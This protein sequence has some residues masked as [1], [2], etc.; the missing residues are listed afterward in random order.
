MASS[1]SAS[2]P[3][4]WQAALD[5][6]LTRRLM[7][8]LQRPGVIGTRLAR[9]VVSRF[10][11]MAGGFPLLPR[12]SQ[13]WSSPEASA[14][15]QVPIV[16]AQ[17]AQPPVEANAASPTASSTSSTSSSA[18]SAKPSQRPIVQ[19]KAVSAS[20][21]SSSLP[22]KSL[23]SSHVPPVAATS[24]MASPS[25]GDQTHSAPITMPIASPAPASKSSVVRPLPTKA[26]HLQSAPSST[27]FPPST[28]HSPPSTL[29]SSLSLHSQRVSG[30]VVQRKSIST[31]AASS[32]SP[33]ISK[34]RDD[35]LQRKVD[36]ETLQRLPFTSPASA[37]PESPAPLPVVRPHVAGEPGPQLAQALLGTP[38]LNLTAPAPVQ[39]VV[40]RPLSATSTESH[41]VQR[42]L[43][44]PSVA[45]L[46]PEVGRARASAPASTLPFSARANH[47]APELGHTSENQA[48]PLPVISH[49]APTTPVI[50]RQAAPVEQQTPSSVIQRAPR[51]GGG[52]GSTSDIDELAEKVQ[53]KLA[54]W[55]T[56]ESERRGLTRWD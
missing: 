1:S 41:V 8:P 5:P 43:H 11:R 20:P 18:L 25:L 39:R 29:H 49:T 32:I 33:S 10:E 13:R 37:S 16:Y 46:T 6:R 19:A 28:L 26:T 23:L 3:P 50:Q 54:H 21:T 56:I 14:A 2:N 17:P 42:A 35:T 31:I 40:V 22:T 4:A 34:Q 36:A 52:G 15:G 44:P 12:L 27:H 55:L 53:A 24:S 48:Q 45:A 9:S 38:A 51:R 30:N 47:T 7:R